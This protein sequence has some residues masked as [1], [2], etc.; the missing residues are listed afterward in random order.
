MQRRLLRVFES[1]RLTISERARTGN[2]LGKLGDPRFRPEAWSLPDDPSMGFVVVRE[3]PFLMGSDPLLDEDVFENELPHHKVVLPRFYVAKFPV[4]VAQF[5]AY[6]EASGAKVPRESLLGIANHPVVWITWHD[7]NGYCDW[8]TDCL[9]TWPGTPEPIGRLLREGGWRMRL[10]SEA[11]WEK[12][13][14]GGDGRIY[15]WGNSFE[16]SKANTRG[17]R[18]NSTTVVGCFPE[19][20]SPWGALDM[21][22]NVWEWTWSLYRDY[23]YASEASREDPETPKH[24]PRV[25]RGGSFYSQPRYVRCATR[26]GYYP[27]S[28]DK[29]TGFR[30]ALVPPRYWR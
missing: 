11:E 22:G 19:G 3:G 9:R 5:K 16:L 7:A 25:L 14:R 18:N 8:L 2:V 4:T 1:G 21:A 13:A 30:V 28:M 15:P 27:H 20:A 23:P 12:A 6:V 29:N 24:V 17:N 26:F 10:P